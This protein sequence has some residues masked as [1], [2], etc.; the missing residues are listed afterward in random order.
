M[1]IDFDQEE[2]KKQKEIQERLAELKKIEESQMS[3]DKGK[4][5]KDEEIIEDYKKEIVEQETK[6]KKLSSFFLKR[7][8]ADEI[9]QLNAEINYRK[10][11]I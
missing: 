9:N 7:K 8:N 3:F 2:Y 4:I 5:E 6:L 11:R 1:K 10:K